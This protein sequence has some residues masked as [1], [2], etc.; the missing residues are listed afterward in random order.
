MPCEGQR[1]ELLDLKAIPPASHWELAPRGATLA[2]MHTSTLRWAVLPLLLLASCAGTKRLSDP[3]ILIRGGGGTELGVSTEY[4]VLFLGSSHSAGRIEI[5]SWFGDG[6]NI[7]LSVVE[8]V[9]DILFTA[10]TEIRLATVPL[11]FIV[12]EPG[13]T[14]VV[15]G[16]TGEGLWQVETQ[17]RWH[18]DVDGILIDVLPEL[19]AEMDQTGAGVFLPVESEGSNMR[20]L[21]LVSGVIELGVDGDRRAYATIVGPK[22][23]WELVTHRKDQGRRKPWV[24]REDTL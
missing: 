9:G 12:P 2:A 8:P 13:A 23:L 3:T 10:E 20:L 1:P 24:Y 6:P 16:R 4:G 18:P 15:R 19:L 14:V 11:T 22:D 7:E 17:L 5:E 21:G